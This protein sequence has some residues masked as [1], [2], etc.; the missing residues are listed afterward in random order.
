M[1]YA[2]IGLGAAGSGLAVSLAKAG[3]AISGWFD[4]DAETRRAVD[5]AGGLSYEGINGQGAVTLP[6]ASPSAADAIDGAS[7]IIVSTTADR[8]EEV[9]RALASALLPDQ[10]VVLHCGYVGGARMFSQALR[11]AGGIENP[12]LAELNNTVH[13]C[14]K[15]NAATVAMRAEKRWLELAAEPTV[16]RHAATQAFL[17]HFPGYTTTERTLESGLNNPNPIGH[18]PATIGNAVLLGR[19][20]GDMTTGVLNFEEAR[21]G[22]VNTIAAAFEAER[23]RLIMALGLDPLPSSV[24]SARAYPAGTRLFGGVPRFGPKLQERFL[25]EDLPCSLVPMESIGRWIGCPTPITTAM[26]ELSNVIAGADFRAD[27]RTVERLGE[28]WIRDQT[29]RL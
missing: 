22:K 25:T 4:R 12:L 3:Q 9:A 28:D 13:L 8:H 20:L 7:A 2:L 18:V 26:I 1:R 29:R 10:L 5:A 17:A 23:D 14:G 15:I 16:L 24:F 11:A 19:D 6:R 21:L 27:G